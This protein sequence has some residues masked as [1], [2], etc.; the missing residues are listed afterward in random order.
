LNNLSLPINKT[1]N[2]PK[3]NNSFFHAGNNK[4]NSQNYTIIQKFNL[5]RK[6]KWKKIYKRKGLVQ[7]RLKNSKIRANPRRSNLQRQ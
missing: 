4:V 1:K 7:I 2:K 6:L 3:E 5:I